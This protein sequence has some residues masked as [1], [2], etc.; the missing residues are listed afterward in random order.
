MYFP[1]SMQR[2]F[3]VNR[4]HEIHQV[5]STFDQFDLG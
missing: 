1:D 2:E 5:S 4:F 3:G